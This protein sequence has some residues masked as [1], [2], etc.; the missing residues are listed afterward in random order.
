MISKEKNLTLREKLA[1][2]EHDQWEA[3]SKDIAETENINPERLKRW[4][5]L[6]GPYESLSE[7]DK[8]KDREWADKVLKC[9]LDLAQL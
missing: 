4:K 1:K 6:W 5:T 8:D 7:K 9:L 2:L 3:W